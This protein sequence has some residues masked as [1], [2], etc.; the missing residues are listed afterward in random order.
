MK[1]ARL[2]IPLIFSAFTMQVALTTQA[3]A[4]CR[5]GTVVACTFLGKPGTKKCIG[6]GEF[7]AC[8]P[9]PPAP[10]SGTVFGKYLILTVV[11]A[12]PGSTAPQTTTGEQSFSSVT[13]ESDS[14]T[15]STKTNSKS[16]KQDY[17]VS[18]KMDCDCVFADLSGGVSF[19]YTKNTTD[20]SALNINKKTTSVITDPGPV[21]D[22][23][24]HNFDQI[25]L[26]L[27]PKYDVTINGTQVSWA[28][29][30]DQSAGLVQ[31]VYAGQLKD[32][33]KIQPGILQDLQAAGITPAD[34]QVILTA[35]PLAQCLPP[36]VEQ[37][38]AQ[39]AIVRPPLPVPC[40]TPAPTAPRYVPT[41][42]NLPYNPPFAAGN[43]VP[44][45][46]YVIDNSSIQ[47][48]TNSVEK[49]YAIGVT[50]SGGVDFLDIFKA[51][52][53]TQDTWTWQDISTTQT[54]T[55]TEQKASLA[56]GG[57]AFGYTGPANMDV[58]YDTLYMTFAFVPNELSPDALHGTISSSQGKPAVGQLVTAAAGGVKYRTYTNAKGEYHFSRQFAGPIDV[59]AGSAALHLPGLEAGK[60]VD[61]RLQ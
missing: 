53:A 8:V 7:D 37:L 13:Y 32:P 49:D 54:Q 60:S 59:Q 44:L 25:W 27:H 28:L 61:L 29:D 23:V 21:E 24:D 16:F 40:F 57:P 47:T 5:P 6:D 18:A 52:L 58:Y 22:S 14:T 39:Q 1:Y 51:T 43:A 17:Q 50:A 56:M 19:E 11:Y 26:F 34:Y 2:A 31:Y 46:T 30:P 35:D 10:V 38:Q 15:G 20:S 48:T 9:N 33:S 3:D 41:N 45:Q 36:V 12:P 55:G 42:I 4:L